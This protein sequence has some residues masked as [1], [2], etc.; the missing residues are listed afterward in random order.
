M[1]I[2]VQ[3]KEQIRQNFYLLFDHFIANEEIRSRV[4]VTFANQKVKGLTRY[5][6]QTEEFVISFWN[7][8]FSEELL[9]KVVAHEF[10]HL[11]LHLFYGWHTH[12]D[13]IFLAY[14]N[15]FLT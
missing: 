12:Q 5:Q 4:T 3:Q 15:H 10:T 6:P 13:E 8:E 9:V 11:Y 14:A 1:S 2:S 7:K